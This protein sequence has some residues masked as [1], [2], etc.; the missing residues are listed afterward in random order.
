MWHA[1]FFVRKGGG[2]EING[3]RETGNGKRE[4]ER[5]FHPLPTPW[6]SPL[7]QG[8]KVGAPLFEEH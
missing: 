6:Y 2:E 1:T 4:T 3:K 8:E 5:F 7:S